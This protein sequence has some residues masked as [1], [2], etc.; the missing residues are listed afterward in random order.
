M[1]SHNFF[2]FFFENIK[3]NS[4]L[5][6][7]SDEFEILRLKKLLDEKI[8]QVEKENMVIFSLLFAIIP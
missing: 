7:H 6:I 2:F 3:M 1:I 4:F 5:C 8:I